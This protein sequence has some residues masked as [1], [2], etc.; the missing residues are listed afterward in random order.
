MRGFP[1]VVL[2]C[3][4]ACRASSSSNDAGPTN[5]AAASDA[6]STV[7]GASTAIGGDRPVTVHVPPGYQAG[8]PMPLV[9]MLH[10]YTASGDIEEAYL[11]LT[12]LADARGFL[13][14]H[15]DGTID[16]LNNHF[17]N[18]TDACC[19]VNASTVD[20]STYLSTVIKQIAARYTV[21]PKRVFLVGHSN[22]AFMSHRMACEHADQIAGIVSLAGAQWTDLTKCKPSAPVNVLQIHGTADTVILYNGGTVLTKPYPSAPTTVADWVTL[23]GCAT[24]ADTS[25]AAIDLDNVLPG[26]ET[27]VSRWSAG[28]SAGSRVELWTIV[29]G[30]HIPSLSA[31]FSSGLVDFLL[32]HPK[33]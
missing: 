3:L 21:D 25:A 13:Y 17:W 4:V 10:G 18:A 23:D 1:A 31:T 29:G 12:P 2:C 28:C 33:P 6:F 15:P 30:S 11:Q 5:D 32:A 20:D 14:A 8:T 27:T 16:S 26:N 22:G 24:T 19:N 9:V 7:D